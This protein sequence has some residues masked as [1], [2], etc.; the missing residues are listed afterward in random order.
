MKA[1]AGTTMELKAYCVKGGTYTV[2]LA[3]LTGLEGT[4]SAKDITATVDGQPLTVEY[5]TNGAFIHVNL[6]GAVEADSAKNIQALPASTEK[7][8]ISFPT[9]GQMTRVTLKR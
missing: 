8:A 1:A 2:R 6:K 4:S 9:G 5:D 7:I 3:G